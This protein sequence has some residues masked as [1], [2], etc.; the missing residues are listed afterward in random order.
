M[1]PWRPKL[2]CCVNVI[3]LN[4]IDGNR[5][6]RARSPSAPAFRR[7]S[8]AACSGKTPYNKKIWVAF[9]DHR[10][11]FNLPPSNKFSAMCVSVI[12]LGRLSPYS[13]DGVIRGD[14][15]LQ[16]LNAKEAHAKGHRDATQ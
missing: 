5:L 6:C 16:L 3:A 10:T 1:S 11:N 13:Y 4:L 14:C 9:D 7:K 2:Q 8:S 12:V 15:A